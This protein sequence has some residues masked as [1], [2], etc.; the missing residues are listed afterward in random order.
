VLACQFACQ[1]LHN[2][3]YMGRKLLLATLV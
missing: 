1:R 2:C 3:S